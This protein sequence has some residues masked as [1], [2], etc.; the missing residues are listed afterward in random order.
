MIK[1]GFLANG[2]MLGWEPEKLCG[3][4]KET[5][6]DSVELISDIIFANGKDGKDF[7]AAADKAGLTIS[8]ILVQRDFVVL[9]KDQR[10]DGIAIT[11]EYM[12]K[13]AAMG[14]D[15]VNFFTGPVPWMPDSITVGKQV[16]MGDA[17]AMT[18]DAFDEL[19]PVAEKLGVKIAVE[20]VWGMLVHDF[21][22][23]KYLIDHYDSDFLGVNLDP[24]HDILYGNTDAAFIVKSWGKKIFHVHVKDAVG[25][26]GLGTFVFPVLGEGNVNFK[27]F[28]DALKEIGYEGAASVEFESWAY[29]Q[30]ILGGSHAASAAPSLEFLKKF[31]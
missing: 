29:R 4:L 20:N 6:Y 1:K 30:N 23:N 3:F 10:K 24:S 14:V 5:G 22:T 21:Y 2:E 16:S 17:W 26:A 31:I 13:A 11:E 8:E 19:L 25:V 9:D 28:F 27:A 7:K 15:V 18:F 12:K